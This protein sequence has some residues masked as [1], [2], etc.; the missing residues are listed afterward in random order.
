[1]PIGWIYEIGPKAFT[2]GVKT[3]SRKI[4]L[5]FKQQDLTR[6]QLQELGPPRM[7]C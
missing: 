7:E 4:I 2:L 6:P 5:M 3:E 1:M